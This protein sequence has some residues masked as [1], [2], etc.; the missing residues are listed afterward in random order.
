MRLS[1][2]TS[3]VCASAVLFPAALASSLLISSCLTTLRQILP[4]S[5]SSARTP[6]S[7]V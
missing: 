4:T 5:R 1:P 6:A 7:R 2:L 3:T